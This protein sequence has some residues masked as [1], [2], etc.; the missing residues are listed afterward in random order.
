MSYLNSQVTDMR[1]VTVSCLVS[2]FDVLINFIGAAI[3]GSSIMVSQGFQ[4]LADFVTTLF[5]LFGVRRSKRKATPRHPLGYG[6]ELFF[7]VLISSLVAFLFSGGLALFFAI[8]QLIRGYNIDY[9][10]VALVILLFG[11]I[12]NGYALSNSLGRLS[13]TSKGRSL[14]AHLRYSS[15]VET[16][17]TLLVDLVGTIS[18]TLGLVALGLYFI[19][20]NAVFDSIGAIFIGLLTML[21]ALF[22]IVDL[23]DLIIGRSPHPSTISGIQEVAE[24]I[25]GVQQILDIRATTVGSNKLFIIL[26][27]HFEDDIDTDDIELITDKIQQTV[28][29]NV[30]AMSEV[31]VEAETP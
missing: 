22:I 30:S 25:A 29:D 26:K 18:A 1:T 5:L 21:G 2:F 27:V 17:M 28:S 24:S 13:S 31:V 19:T 11:L 20:D 23:Y 3:T 15:L 16:K 10:F 14:V 7:W 8:Q 9:E 6:R 12:T 4:G